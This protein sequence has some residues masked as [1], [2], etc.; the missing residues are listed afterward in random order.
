M[1][2]WQGFRLCLVFLPRTAT[3]VYTPVW[4]ISRPD[5]TASAKAA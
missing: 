5:F 4:A 3:V 2:S 1:P